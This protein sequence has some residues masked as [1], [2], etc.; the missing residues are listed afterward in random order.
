M[1]GPN[2]PNR[3]CERIAICPT[4]ANKVYVTFGGFN[5]GN[6]WRTTDGG[7]NW[8]NISSGLPAAPVNSI[9]IA[10]SDPNTLYIGTEVG[11]YGYV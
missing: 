6:V 9:T 11:I 10:P 5:S 4:N 7:V 1:G 8:V 2:L 3:Y